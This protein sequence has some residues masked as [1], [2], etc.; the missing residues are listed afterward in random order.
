MLQRGY[1]LIR[2]TRRENRKNTHFRVQ[3]ALC[4]LGT[5]WAFPRE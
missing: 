1:V 5:N 2:L 4:G 3:S